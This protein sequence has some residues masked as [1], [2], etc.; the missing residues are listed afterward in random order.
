MTRVTFGR[1]S[2][3][4][5]KSKLEND[6]TQ[7]KRWRDN[8]PIENQQQ[9]Q[10]ERQLFHHFPSF[11]D[12]IDDILNFHLPQHIRKGVHSK[13]QDLNEFAMMPSAL[14]TLGSR[15]SPRKDP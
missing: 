6:N 12:D 1:C 14:H 2:D 5:S 3:T 4:G 11:P 9:C 10:Q 7:K 8:P 13:E 15:A